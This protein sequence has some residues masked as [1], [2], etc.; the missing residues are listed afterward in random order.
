VIESVKLVRSQTRHQVKEPTMI[1]LHTN[2]GTIV[3]E[4]DAA[5]APKT[6][7]NFLAYVENPAITTTRSSTASSTAS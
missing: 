2:F 4:L 7:K 3:L 1:K 6:V 5:K